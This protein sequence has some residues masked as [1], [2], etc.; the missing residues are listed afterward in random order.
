MTALFQTTPRRQILG[1]YQSP[2]TYER[3]VPP[4]IP[5]QIRMSQQRWQ[6]FSTRIRVGPWLF[7]RESL[8][9]ARHICALTAPRLKTLYI[10]VIFATLVGSTTVLPCRTSVISFIIRPS[11][12][13]VLRSQ[14]ASLQKVLTLVYYSSMPWGKAKQLLHLTTY[15]KL[16]LTHP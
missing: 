8:T 14:V 5:S 4:P 16:H 3:S 6:F 15:Y 10:Q 9:G 1:H 2:Q 12:N 13:M 11:V 7:C